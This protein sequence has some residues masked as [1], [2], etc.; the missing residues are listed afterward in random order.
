MT[1]QEHVITKRV[2]IRLINGGN[3]YN[4]LLQRLFTAFIKDFAQK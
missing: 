2:K 3:R 4:A 1:T